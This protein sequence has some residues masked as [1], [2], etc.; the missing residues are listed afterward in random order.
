MKWAE[1]EHTTARQ[2]I[3]LKMAL[4]FDRQAFPI[5]ISQIALQLNYCSE[6]VDNAVDS[7][8]LNR[9]HPQFTV[10]LHNLM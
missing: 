9:T 3:A 4:P 2:R 5:L 6:L 10:E 8:S 1:M 7:Q